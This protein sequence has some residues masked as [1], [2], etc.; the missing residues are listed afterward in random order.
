MSIAILGWGSLL[1]DDH[2]KFATFKEQHYPW[3]F[4]GPT[5]RLEFSRVSE[6]RDGALTLVIEAEPH[7][8]DCVVAYALSRRSELEDAVCDVRSREGTI[9]ANVGFCCA[10]PRKPV[11]SRDGRVLDTVRQWLVA[12][13]HSGAVWTDLRS[14]FDKV[15][16]PQATFSVTNA[17]A[18]VRAL[19]LAGQTKAAEYVWRAPD[20]VQTPLRAALQAEAWFAALKPVLPAQQI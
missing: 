17:I 3:Q 6:S 15:S 4:N 9:M 20:L 13:G 10:D 7:G 14:N 18:H 19:P 1:W 5:L 2:P 12:R 11:R 16:K 8:A